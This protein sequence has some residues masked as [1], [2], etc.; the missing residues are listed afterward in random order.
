MKI[1]SSDHYVVLGWNERAPFLLDNLRKLLEPE[2]IPIVV[3]SESEEPPYENDYIF[4]LK[5]RPTSEHDLIRANVPSAKAVIL[6]ANFTG[7]A[8]DC[9]GDARTVLTALG[10]KKLNPDANITAE[11]LEPENI[12]HLQLAGVSEILNSN[13]L[14][15]SLMAR[16][17]KNH[18]L[19]T[20]VTE[21]INAEPGS[22]ITRVQV[23]EAMAEMTAGELEDFLL[24]EKHVVPLAAG[25]PAN[26][27]RYSKETKL[28]PGELLM[29]ISSDPASGNS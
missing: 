16:S 12:H 18:G 24:R 21:M 10:V 1:S 26:M 13:M 5:G 6:L 9:D 20:F 7:Q 25:T 22:G 3:M 19:I 23:D 28:T 29:V 2:R 8:G 11:V 14:L 17:A 4:F 27:R 15:G